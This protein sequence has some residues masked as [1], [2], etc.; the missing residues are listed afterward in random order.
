LQ[1]VR[2]F[3]DD[4]IVHVA[5]KVDPLADVEVINLEL[6]LA[7][8][9][10]IEKRLERLKKGA[11]CRARRVASERCAGAGL[12]KG[13]QPVSR[14]RHACPTAHVT[15]FDSFQRVCLVHLQAPHAHTC[16]C[17]VMALV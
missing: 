15:A 12:Y 7:D 14:A 3:D 1:V 4:D 2:C 5:G 16:S 17:G 6:A 11:A 9:G 13:Q 10:Q 8:I